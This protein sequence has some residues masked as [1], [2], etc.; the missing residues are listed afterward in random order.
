MNFVELYSIKKYSES[1]VDFSEYLRNCYD[2][3]GRTDS[4][5]GPCYEG[6]CI[7]RWCPAGF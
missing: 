4:V 5:E 6:V 1:E 7:G 3:K 2:L